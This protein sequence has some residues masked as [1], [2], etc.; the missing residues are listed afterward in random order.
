[1]GGVGPPRR[2]AAILAADVVGYSY[3]MG[4]DEAGTLT[5]LKAHRIECFEPLVA[6][7]RGRVVKLMGDGALVEFA[8]V[9][10]AVEC[11]V[12]VQKG[13]TEREADVPD[14]ERIRLRIGINLGDVIVDDDDIFGDGVNVAARLEG[15][16][17][18]GGVCLS[19]QA[20]DQVAG[21]LNLVF[22]DL[23]AHEVKNIARAIRVYRIEAIPGEVSAA[24]AEG[25][26]TRPAVAVL[27][28]TNI[29]GDPE[30]AYFADGLTE[31]VITALS[32]WRSF[33]V[34]ARNSTFTYKGQAVD[35]KRVG[36]ELGARYV[37]E[38]S[39]R[40]AGNRVRVTAQFIDAETG[41]HVWVERYDRALEDVFDLQDELTQRMAA[42]IEPELERAELKKAA[43]KRTESLSAWD[44]YLRGMAAITQRSCEG[45]ARAREMFERA[46]ARD[47]NYSDGWTG[48]TLSH[49]RD[50]SEGCTDDREATL[51]RAFE[52]GHRAV[53]LDGASSSAHF[54][55]G[56]AYVWAE[57]YDLAIAE[58]ELALRLN[59]N[60][61][62]ACMGLGNRLDLAGRTEEGIAQMEHSLQ[63][64]PRD[65]NLASYMGFLARAYIRL[66]DYEK[67][68]DRARSMVQL[69]PNH[70][71]PLY[72]L[73]VC[74]AHLDRVEEA[75][76][77][78][79]GCERLRAGFLTQR[80]GWRPY[81]DADSNE[82]F[83]A[84]LRR[85]RLLP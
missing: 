64:N 13:V 25:M 5:R 57:R 75:R 9:V 84:G 63:L 61:A 34:I 45:N 59:P 67:A 32:L 28:F 26:M 73:A 58:T 41:H 40:K 17:E 53:A 11:A 47:P 68:L 51:A 1:M 29:G 81:P 24:T 4:R 56:T 20:Y 22:T 30:Q 43:A 70:P 71:D 27:P 15:L 50:I 10:D 37:L 74:L 46:V 44:C 31:D 69:R 14:D 65:P 19:G 48:L 16:A 85:H 38:G 35:V 60:N 18:P 72:R 77:A 36:R 42:T 21:K 62:H 66:G 52:A 76:A 2:L 23:G 33:P 8:S 6:R 83:F 39:V 54:N 79:E 55:L 80:A 3:L 49:V 7:H 78:L 12:A 82:R